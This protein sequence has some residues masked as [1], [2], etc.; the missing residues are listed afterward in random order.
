M[1][2]L[3]LT[4][5]IL[6]GL[7]APAWADFQQGVDA[8]DRGDFAT[9]LKEFKLLARQS[10]AEAQAKLGIMY[11]KGLGVPQDY[12][13]AFDWFRRAADQGNPGA[14]IN[15]GTMYENGKGVIQDYV[16]AH[17]WFNLAVSKLPLRSGSRYVA[18]YGR[19]RVT[20]KM[21]KGQIAEAQRMAREWKPKK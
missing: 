10:N 18:N 19:S 15:L 9:A 21:T 16:R 11:S 20:I 5:T 3:V 17:M 2:R 14:Q 12:A 1:K 13:Q 4:F 8:Y 7:A 6:I